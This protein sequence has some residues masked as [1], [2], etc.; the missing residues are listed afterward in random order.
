MKEILKEKLLAR[1]QSIN[2]TCDNLLKAIDGLIE[3][4]KEQMTEKI[5]SSNHLYDDCV[6]LVAY[7]HALKDMEKEINTIREDYI[8]VLYDN[9]MEDMNELYIMEEEIGE[10]F[11]CYPLDLDEDENDEWLNF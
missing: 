4:K 10:D 3:N 2:C 7:V 6:D 1:E 5:A 8:T 9:Y 11:T